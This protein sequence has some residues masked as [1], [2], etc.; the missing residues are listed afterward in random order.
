MKLYRKIVIGS[1]LL[2]LTGGLS[3]CDDFLDKEPQSNASPENTLTEANQLAYY[4][5]NL[6]A[7]I[8]PSHSNWSYGI[9]G[10]DNNTDNQTGVSAHD[11]YTSDRWK[12][13][14]NETDNWKFEMIYR[15][16]Y[17]F[18]LVTPRYG[19]DLSGS[20]NTITGSLPEIKHYIG[21]MYF[22]RAC[23][24]FKRYQMF[25]D[26]PIITEPLADNSAVLTEASKRK[27]RNEVAR[28]ILSDLDKAITLLSE[29]STA[30]TRINK[31][32]ALLL[33]SRVAL[34][35][36]TWLKY[37]KG[38][39]F[40]PNGTDWPGAQKDYN[41]GYQ[42]PSGS[43]DEEI[44]YFLDQAMDASKQVAEE[45][46]GK[47]T[48]NTGTLQQSATDA[49][50][51]YFDMF[52]QEDLSGV[53]E[54]LLWRQYGRGLSTHNVN[55]AAGRGNYRIGVTRG[56]VNSFLMAD[57]TPVYSHG[58]YAAGD[59]YYKGDKTIADVR[60]NRDPR[61]SIF[62]KEPGQNNILFELDNSE[63][64]EAVLV[65]P[66]PAITNGDGERGYATGY[67][68]RKGGS[69][70]KKYYANGG[71][72]TAAICYRAT[73]ALLNY[74][75]AS[76]VRKGTLDGTA[77]EYWTIIRQRSHV[78]TD[79]DNTISKTVM[80]KE[81]ENDW[82][83]YSA[84]NLIDATLYNIRRERRSE[85]IAEGLRYMDLCRW[86]SMDQL[87]TTPYHIEGFHL[88]NT[89]MESWYN[90]LI[91]DGSENANTSSKDKSEYL[92]PFERYS[93]QAAYNGMT[94]KMAHYLQPIM[95][96]QFQLTTTSG[97][98][99]S[100]STIYQNPYWPLVADQPAEK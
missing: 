89:P 21:E 7:D 65:E 15:C 57:G 37:F 97:S 35:E 69:F 91:A 71:G 74:M 61:L 62:L 28:F 26:F 75:E 41:S 80:A 38:T 56:L 76:Y 82:G 42:Y 95:I 73:E 3:S 24:Y 49:A 77:R 94:W 45:Y 58:T 87:M 100:S 30:K 27:P 25:G 11:R 16:N 53:Q 9:F 54:V 52:A 6:Y 8:L 23:E 4:A 19:E 17:F 36:G 47:L 66:Y 13:A 29:S 55:S 86:R 85:L 33:K 51:P 84:G 63:G 48:V 14:H 40:V 64:T 67:A 10:E 92:R 50:N 31:D 32:A 5:N 96:K 59:G 20:A 79:I 72:Y 81:A 99:L 1:L 88:W 78:S 70:N 98:D 39:A 18:S 83:A 34:F 60:A 22:L 68:L 90:N 93:A 44:N 43:I 2:A 46:K 12:V